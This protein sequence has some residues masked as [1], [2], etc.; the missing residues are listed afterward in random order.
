M[1]LLSVNR[2]S[3]VQS[4][5]TCSFVDAYRYVTW[6]I[7]SFLHVTVHPE[8]TSWA[9]ASRPVTRRLAHAH[10]ADSTS[11]VVCCT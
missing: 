5:C 3:L 11:T 9:R 10:D 1:K 7:V 2:L 4:Y 8:P 6:I